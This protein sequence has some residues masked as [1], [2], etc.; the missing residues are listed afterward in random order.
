MHEHRRA[1]VLVELAQTAH[2]IDMR[3]GADNGLYSELVTAEEVQNAIDFIAGI[4]DQR[5]ARDRIA[6]DGAIALQHAHG[7]GD[8]DQPFGGGIQGGEAVA[9]VRDYSIGTEWICGDRYMCRGAL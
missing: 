5:F 9:H 3:V 8:V 2:V 6:D 7:D 4:N 1:R